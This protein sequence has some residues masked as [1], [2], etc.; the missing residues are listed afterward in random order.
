MLAIFFPHMKL[1]QLL[2]TQ[3]SKTL[4][5]WY[6]DYIFRMHI[7]IYTLHHLA[8]ES[9]LRNTTLGS[10]DPVIHGSLNTQYCSLAFAS[11]NPPAGMSLPFFSCVCSYLSSGLC[12][13]LMFLDPYWRSASSARPQPPAH[14]LT[15]AM[16]PSC[17]TASV[18]D[19]GT[20]PISQN[21]TWHTVRAQEAIIRMKY[22]EAAKYL[23][24]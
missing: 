14:P 3:S 6:A 18:S 4:R 24:S 19:Q 9:L 8:H 22:N 5:P 2:E 17:I 21:S 7:K 1:T 16:T 10:H 20:C 11:V 23:I 13:G 15:A 12:V